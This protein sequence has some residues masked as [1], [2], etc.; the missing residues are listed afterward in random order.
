VPEIQSVNDIET[1]RLEAFSDGVFAVVITIMVLEIKPPHG[2]DISDL[3]S[4]LP[5]FLAYLLSFTFVG[6]YWNNH[7]HLLR[8]AKRISGAVMWSN[9]S[10]LFCIS[11]IPFV[12]AWVGEGNNHSHEWPA[13]LYGF[14]GIAAAMTYTVLVITISKCNRDTGF[15]NAL[16]HDTKGKLSLLFYVI[17]SAGAF[18]NPWISYAF[19][20][21]VS[22]MWF[23]PDR[24]LTNIE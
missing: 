3:H 18:I 14:V 16:G 11:L 23:V 12:T 15:V 21:L 17:G 20:V 13:A 2:A 22:L 19:Y 9:L 1:S 7:H 8:A 5:K 4:V 10:L 24:R 6:I